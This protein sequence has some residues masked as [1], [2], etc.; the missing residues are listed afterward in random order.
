SDVAGIGKQSIHFAVGS[1]LP[2]VTPSD[3]RLTLVSK[4]NSQAIPVDE[5]GKFLLPLSEDY[6]KDQAVIRTN[7]PKK[8]VLFRVSI[9]WDRAELTF[10][11]FENG[12]RIRYGNL[13]PST[14]TFRRALV[15]ADEI[16][17]DENID[18]VTTRSTR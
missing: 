6:V 8:T 17:E 3:I 9:T 1:T 13:F 7:Q 10:E 12:M 2:D 14:E 16:Q 11:P 15:A 4:S 18:R 5:S